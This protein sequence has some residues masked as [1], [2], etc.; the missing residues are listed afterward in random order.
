MPTENALHQLHPQGVLSVW[1]WGR[2]RGRGRVVYS[3]RCKEFCCSWS[4]VN[5]GQLEVTKCDHFLP[6]RS[7]EGPQRVVTDKGILLL[8]VSIG[9]TELTDQLNTFQLHSWDLLLLI[10]GIASSL[11]HF[12]GE[13]RQVDTNHQLHS[14]DFTLLLCYSVNVILSPNRFKMVQTN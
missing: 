10:Q 2:G 4:S 14:R 9:T 13:S 7:T 11:F 6:P 12:T 1:G 3:L 5:V 8:F